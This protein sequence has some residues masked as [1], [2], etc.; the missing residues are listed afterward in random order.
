MRVKVNDSVFE[1][2]THDSFRSI[3]DNNLEIA[4][5]GEKISLEEVEEA[6]SDAKKISLLNEENEE[7][8]TFKDLG[9]AESLVEA[10][11][12]LGWKTPLKIQAEAIPLA[13]GGC[14]FIEFCNSI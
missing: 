10:C 3:G 5:K 14:H 1:L 9:L 8:K 2:I 4:L 7:V 6:F 11:E 12:K 13:L